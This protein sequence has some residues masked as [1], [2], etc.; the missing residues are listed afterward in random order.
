MASNIEMVITTTAIRHGDSLLIKKHIV[1][2]KA[3]FLSRGFAPFTP[4]DHFVKDLLNT[5]SNEH[6]FVRHLL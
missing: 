3:S 5:N 6:I 2:Q 1:S 4:L